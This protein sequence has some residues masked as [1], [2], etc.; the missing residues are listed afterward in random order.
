M[1]KTT[2]KGRQNEKD[3]SGYIEK[4][5][6]VVAARQT[7]WELEK[8]LSETTTAKMNSAKSPGS[9]N[10]YVLRQ[11]CKYNIHISHLYAYN[12]VTCPLSVSQVTPFRVSELSS[13]TFFQRQR[14]NN[15][16]FSGDQ[17]CIV[18]NKLPTFRG[19]YTVLTN[20]MHVS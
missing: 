6:N 3:K 12:H 7:A 5:S 9:S 8:S 13:E 2:I 15:G 10:T 14:S 16:V 18:H 11:Q 17:Q 1:S 20:K 4:M 19:N